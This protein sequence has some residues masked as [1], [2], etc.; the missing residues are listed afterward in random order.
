MRE[1]VRQQRAHTPA[2]ADELAKLGVDH[3]VRVDADAKSLRRSESPFPHEGALVGPVRDAAPVRG[4]ADAP[5]AYAANAARS[6]SVEQEA[7][8]LSRTEPA[9]VLQRV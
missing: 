4:Q 8:R 2:L 5:P 7:F 6:R 1:A 3:A 9:V